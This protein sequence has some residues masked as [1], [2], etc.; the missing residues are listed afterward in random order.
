MCDLIFVGNPG[1]GKSSTINAMIGRP[2]MGAGLS[3]AGSGVTTIMRKHYHDG[4]YYVDTPGLKDLSDV[5]RKKACDSIRKALRADKTDVKAK[6]IFMMTL[7]GGRIRPDDTATIK[8][9]LDATPIKSN[10]YCIVFNK[11]T[12]KVKQDYENN[13]EFKA[14]LF[15][16]L[17]ENK[18]TA[19]LYFNLRSDHLEDTKAQDVDDWSVVSEEIKGLKGF[20]H[21]VV[22]EVVY[23]AR[24][25]K[26]IEAN[27]LDE[28]RA[29][30]RTMIERMRREQAYL[31]RETERL[32]RKIRRLE[33]DYMS[34][35]RNVQGVSA[36]VELASV[37]AGGITARAGFKIGA[38]S[39]GI[40]LGPISLKFW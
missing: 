36:G 39:D 35:S 29:Q 31:R 25:V 15:K 3:E 17:P 5:M 2:V 32:N 8:L 9:V 21:N 34:Y 10:E 4:Y 16:A 30:Q 11:V 22:R 37:T 7:E 18:K 33:A 40:H 27:R 24:D 12:N 6:L 13:D 14:T 38:G 28:I 26:T 19:Y 1:A 23:K 20:I